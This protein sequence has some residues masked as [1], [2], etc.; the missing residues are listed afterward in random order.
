MLDMTRLYEIVDPRPIAAEAKYT[1]FLPSKAELD[2]VGPGDLLKF[3][4]R[5]NPPSDKWNAE[6]MWV[7]VT[8]VTNGEIEGTLDNDPRDMPLVKR[9]CIVRAPLTHVLGTE[10]EDPN[11]RTTLR[12]GPVRGYWERCLVD[13]AVLDGQTKVQYIYREQPDMYPDSGWRIRG[14]LQPGED[15]S[16]S[17]PAYVAVGAALN[18][19]D[20]WL[21]FIDDPVGSAYDRNSVDD[22]YAQVKSRSR[23]WHFWKF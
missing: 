21:K 3:M 5:S 4:I 13:Q 7:R 6:R 8:S 2:L 19:D 10:F 20:S 9:G 16:A 17:K 11:K 12:E 1:F 23:W 14:F 15:A 22:D 18:Q